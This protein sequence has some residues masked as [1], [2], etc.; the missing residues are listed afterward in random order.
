MRMYRK[1]YKGLV[2]WLIGFLALMLVICFLPV[3]DAAVMTR[4]LANLCTISIAH[5]TWLIWRT[6][7]V[8]WYNGISFEEAEQAGS[9]R[10]KAYALRHFQLFGMYALV[11][12]GITIIAQLLHLP[13]WVDFNLICAGL[14][15]AAFRTMAYRL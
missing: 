3:D 15:A 14:I 11:A 13:W 5:L 12:L 9:E 1:S 8:Y 7:Q 6:E 2:L 4:L 10:R